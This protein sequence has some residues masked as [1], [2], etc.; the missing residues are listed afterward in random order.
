MFSGLSSL[1]IEGVD[2]EAGTIVVRAATPPGPVECPGCA[3][4][5][6]R[7]HGY[8]ERHLADVP[9]GGRRVL[10]RVRAR[11]MRCPTVGCSR[12]TFREQLAG[13]LE[14]Y[15][16]RTA[17]LATQVG[18]VVRELAGRASTR[19][20]AGLGIALSRQTAL[21][22]LLRLPVPARPVPPVV[23]VDDF[24]LRKRRRYATVIINAETGERV[25]VLADRSAETLEA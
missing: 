19:V 3:V 25:D 11:R 10:L 23:G 20:L 7:V 4:E 21:R 9:V 5:T 15:Q 12:Q 17:R 1:F 8:V 14:R 13:V 2:E 6:A 18:G 22:A 24:A 16:R